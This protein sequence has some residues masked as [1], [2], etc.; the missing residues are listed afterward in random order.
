MYS[1]NDRM[2]NECGAVGGIRIDKGNKRFSEKTS[3][4]ATLSITDLM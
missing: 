3:P 4:N 2:S 1:I